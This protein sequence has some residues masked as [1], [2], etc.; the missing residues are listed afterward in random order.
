MLSKV[1]GRC[2]LADFLVEVV[3]SGRENK[4]SFFFYCKSL[5]LAHLCHMDFGAT[6]CQGQLCK[7]LPLPC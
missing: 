6:F 3:C 5:L 1:C 2:V 4:Q 7:F